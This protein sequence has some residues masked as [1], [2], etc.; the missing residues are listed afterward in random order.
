MSIAGKVVAI[1][2]S[3]FI[4]GCIWVLGASADV[5]VDNVRYWTA[6]DHTRVVFDLTEEPEFTTEEQKSELII[7]LPGINYT[8]NLQPNMAISRPGVTGIVLEPEQ[9]RILLDI[10]KE[11]KVFKLPPIEDKP[12]RL[13]VDVS[14]PVMEKK[15]EEPP[16]G[17]R[18]KRSKVI[19]IDP[20][21]GGDDPGAIGPRKTKEKDIV[22]AI[23]RKI[24][25]RVNRKRGFR[26]LLTRDGDYYVSFRKRLRIARD[27]NAD[28]FM[29]IHADAE[30][31]HTAR[32][33]SIYVLSLRGASSE[34]ARILARKENLADIIG[35]TMI[36]EAMLDNEAEPI[37]LNMV[38]TDTINAS[39]YFGTTVLN[40]LKSCHRVKF[41]QVQ[42]APFM[43]LKLPE[44][45]SILIE[46]GYISH[47]QEER[48]LR[49]ERFQNVLAAAIADTA[50]AYLSG[51]K[52]VP[53]ARV[54]LTNVEEPKAPPQKATSTVSYR[55]KKG[56]SL[57]RIAKKYGTTTAEIMAA[58]N[59]RYNHPKLS[60]GQ[61]LK[62]PV[63][64]GKGEGHPP[65]K[66]KREDQ[67]KTVSYRV[68][69][70]E[71]WIT[72]ADRCGMS[73][74]E[75]R[76][77]NSVRRLVAGQSIRIPSQG[78]LDRAQV[79]YY[80]V[81]KGDTLDKVAARYK[82]S[83]ARLK[84]LNK[85]KKLSPLQYGELILVP[86]KAGGSKS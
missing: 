70:G 52:V 76:A 28:L 64:A 30:H 47:R 12:H 80:R 79:R 77:L 78:C 18:T 58:N 10:F 32:G 42:K 51:T 82:I 3:L 19:V 14:L 44:I 62:I 2:F 23:A 4:A 43:V 34:A 16:T 26:A 45:P 83:V 63:V 17:A 68:A 1:L 37:L 15:R 46:L 86:R 20:G 53:K 6:P 75:L 66:D 22:L 33:A 60:V 59:L 21:H 73:E 72:I 50:T 55:V 74:R 29:S 7:R 57:A 71:T 69:K 40:Y 27:N 85:H 84:E 38:Q 11:V 41:A 25:E 24:C 56:D 5:V 54:E 36:S 67:V 13:I 65:K 31:S 35:G 81:K 61:V 49:N 48:L 8:P 39:R 9:I